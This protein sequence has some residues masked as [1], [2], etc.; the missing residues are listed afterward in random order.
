V[1]VAGIVVAEKEGNNCEN[2]EEKDL[3]KVDGNTYS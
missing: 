1:E 3:H 2:E